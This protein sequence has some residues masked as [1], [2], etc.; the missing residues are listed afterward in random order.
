MAYISKFNCTASIV[1][2][3]SGIPTKICW[4]FTR[5]SESI[6]TLGTDVNIEGRLKLYDSQHQKT[7]LVVDG[8]QTQVLA[9]CMTIATS[10]LLYIYINV[11][12]STSIANEKINNL[13]VVFGVV[14]TCDPHY[15]QQATTPHNKILIF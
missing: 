1:G 7:L 3:S 6:E 9:D 15:K 14:V 13:A 2:K 12:I 8:S 5:V 10:G 11:L 4:W